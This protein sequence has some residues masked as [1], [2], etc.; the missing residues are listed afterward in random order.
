M[1]KI[2]APG[3]W[4]S[5]VGAAMPAHEAADRYLR[6]RLAGVCE[7]LPLAS[8]R[9]HK[10]A[11]Y[12]HQ[13]RVAT[14]RS[15]AALMA[16][17]PCIRK[18]RF[19]KMRKHLKRIRR[20]AGQARVSDVHA[21]IFAKCRD[22]AGKTQR[23]ILDYVLNRTL[24]DRADA[25][26]AIDK[27]AKRYRGSRLRKRCRKLLNSIHGPD[28]ADSS[29]P[30]LVEPT[31]TD[32][33]NAAI[34]ALVDRLQAAADRDLSCL[35]QLHVL[36]VEGKRLRY[37]MEIFAPCFADDFRGEL[38]PRIESLQEHLGGINDAHEVVRRLERYLDS[39]QRGD[40]RPSC[41]WRR[42]PRSE[43]EL[44]QGLEDLT[45]IFRS[46]LER[47]RDAFLSWWSDFEPKQVLRSLRDAAAGGSTA[48]RPDYDSSSADMRSGSNNGVASAAP[49][50]PMPARCRSDEEAHV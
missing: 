49:G 31:L 11:E 21:S 50:R 6:A 39:V 16:F 48:D 43:S 5:E 42:A 47:E 24:E 34:P 28:R 7:L 41:R 44:R 3:K 25:Q 12:V 45:M 2:K 20:A 26:S 17:R 15:D 23:P 32:I 18:K 29:D 33:A 4:L 30:E 35:D 40:D 46:Q 13:L 14:R 8:R 22:G 9:Y 38:Y 27:V 36:R 19:R 10:D 1:G 37:A